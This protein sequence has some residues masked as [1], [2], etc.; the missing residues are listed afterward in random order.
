[1]HGTFDKIILYIST[2]C[3]RQWFSTADPPFFF[4][5]TF[6]FFVSGCPGFICF[7]KTISRKLGMNITDIVAVVYFFKGLQNETVF[8]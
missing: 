4:V 3:F 1:M 6:F 5:I 2:E 8:D 7:I